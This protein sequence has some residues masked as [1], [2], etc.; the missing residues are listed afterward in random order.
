[1]TMI[2]DAVPVVGVMVIDPM[3]MN[4]N[5]LA[6][7]EAVAQ[8]ELREPANRR[9]HNLVVAASTPMPGNGIHFHVV[10]VQGR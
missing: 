4:T 1:M 3:A 5:A 8:G 9:V 10:H 7:A 6:A 2:L